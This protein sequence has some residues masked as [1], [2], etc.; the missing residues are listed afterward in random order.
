MLTNC[1]LDSV[2]GS[3][4]REN[5]SITIMDNGNNYGGGVVGRSI[6]WSGGTQVYTVKN[7]VPTDA[8]ILLSQMQLYHDDTTNTLY[9]RIR[10]ADGTYRTVTLG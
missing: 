9:A 1:R 3:I 2:G 7:T 10:K 8:D 4:P 6:Q 5:N